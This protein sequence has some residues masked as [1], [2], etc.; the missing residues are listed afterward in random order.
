L[1]LFYSLSPCTFLSIIPKHFIL[2]R[3]CSHH[4]FVSLIFL[5]VIKQ[6]GQCT[7][8]HN[9][10]ARSP[11]QCCRAKAMRITYSDCVFV[12]CI[13]QQEKCMRPNILPSVACLAVSYFSTLSHKQH[14]FRGKN[15]SKHKMCVLV[16]S[17]TFV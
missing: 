12:V 1:C 15:V 5:S 9:I 10:E 14:D 17:T 16:L 8:K 13:I 3:Y 7:C 2:C 6:N 11:N 4:S